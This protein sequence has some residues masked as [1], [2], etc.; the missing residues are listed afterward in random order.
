MPKSRKSAPAGNRKSPIE[1][2]RVALHA[3][4]VLILVS[5]SVCLFQICRIFVERRIAFPERPPKVTLADRPAWMSDFLA[6][7]IMKT[8]EPIGLHSA[9]DR[10]LLIDTANALKSNPWVRQV[11]QIRR[12]FDQGP[13]DTLEVDCEYRAPVALVPWEDYFCLVD[14]QGIRLPEEYSAAQL[15]KI[16]FGSDGKVNVRLVQGVAQAPPSAGVRWGGNDLE[17]GLELAKLLAGRDFAEQI[18]VIDV[19]NFDGRVNSNEAQIVLLTQF[20]TQIRWGRPPSAQDGIVE[21]AASTKLDALEKIYQQ[22]GRVDANQLWIDVRFDRVT[23]PSN[24][25]RT[26]DADH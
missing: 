15:P 8:A 1:M 22:T 20:G 5:G 17:A 23:C 7:Q 24:D 4:G 14:G 18:R 12:V 16:I 26:A 10:Q 25:V 6:D 13:A 2:W 21:V 3:M 11:N 9:Y 19:S